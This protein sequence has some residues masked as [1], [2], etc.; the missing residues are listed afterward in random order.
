MGNSPSARLNFASNRGF[1]ATFSRHK[2]KNNDI[3]Y[4]QSTTAVQFQ[5]DLSRHQQTEE[6]YQYLTK[7]TTFS[8]TTLRLLKYR[9]DAID[10]TI[11]A[12]GQVSIEE[13]AKVLEMDPNSILIRRF[14]KYMDKSSMGSL[15]FRNFATAL[16]SLNLTASD[17]EKIKLSF[18]LY[19]L[20][21]DQQIDRDECTQMVKLALNEI[22]M[23]LSSKQIEVIVNN[24][25]RETDL[26]GDGVI[27]Y[28]EY[29]VYCRKHPRILEPFRLDITNIIYDEQGMFICCV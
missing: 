17:E 7:L 22:N 14:F 5:R 20:N 15:N 27:D 11:E 29:S 6:E 4:S 26:N 19:D 10:Q 21:D 18:F 12:D 9:F 23:K 24:T 13:F 8:A 28:E 16:S 25:F 3:E 1:A 2:Q